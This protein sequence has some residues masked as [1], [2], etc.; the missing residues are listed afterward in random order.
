MIFTHIF[1]Y[2]DDRDAE[3]I[4]RRGTDDSDNSRSPVA[5]SQCQGDVKFGH[6]TLKGA[7]TLLPGGT[8]PSMRSKTMSS[9]P[10][11]QGFSTLR[12]ET[13][14]DPKTATANR[15]LPPIGKSQMTVQEN[16]F[17]TYE[18]NTAKLPPIDPLTSKAGLATRKS[19]SCSKKNDET[20]GQNATSAEQKQRRRLQS[21]FDD[22]LLAKAGR[23]KTFYEQN[24]KRL[25][26]GTAKEVESTQTDVINAQKT[27]NYLVSRQFETH[28]VY[29]DSAGSRAQHSKPQTRE[30]Y[31][32]LRMS[33]F[34][35][36]VERLSVEPSIEAV[37]ARSNSSPCVPSAEYL[38][39]QTYET[40]NNHVC[41]SLV[42]NAKNDTTV[43]LVTCDKGRRNAIC[44]VLEKNIVPEYGS[45]LYDMRQNLMS[46]S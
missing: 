24:A 32:S 38:R 37:K 4:R 11:C 27:G 41:A 9:A 8:Q 42:T 45:S 20:F 19:R 7:P 3:E 18:K 15:V 40:S 14:K 31:K 36:Q 2:L 46:T 44:E 34:N 10:L 13:R 30:L 43:H 16:N 5:E 25:D 12:A 33:E 22:M 23:K 17:V 26:I 35:A 1:R 28:N 29:C 39:L 6:S 21:S